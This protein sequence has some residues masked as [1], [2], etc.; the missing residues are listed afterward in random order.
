MVG[1]RPLATINDRGRKVRLPQHSK[2]IEEFLYEEGPHT[3]PEIAS[4]F[5]MSHGWATD[6]LGYMK[7]EGTVQMF[8]RKTKVYWMLTN[9]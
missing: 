3:A 8:Y 4:H 9:P 5:N 7:A 1:A 6:I 2:N